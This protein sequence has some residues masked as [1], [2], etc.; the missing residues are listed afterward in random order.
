MQKLIDGLHRFQAQVFESQKALFEE[1]AKGQKPE[2]LFIT[3]SD[4]RI[5]PN[6]LT[7]TKPGDL[8]IVRNAGNIVPPY[9]P[10][11]G[12]EQATIEYGV[13]VLGVQHIVVC[14]HSLCGAMKAVATGEDLSSLPSVQHWLSHAHG[15]RQIIKDHYGHLKGEALLTAT[16]E[17]NVLTQL[18]HLQTHPVVRSAARTGK[19]ALHGWVYKMETGKVFQYDHRERQ[20]VSLEEVANGLAITSLDQHA[21]I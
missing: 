12:G 5:N 19:V 17:E 1:L 14:G 20:F 18:E 10:H 9:S 15:T 16:V 6:L 4:S 11:S 3:C 8:F 21:I 7:Q 13:A 2:V